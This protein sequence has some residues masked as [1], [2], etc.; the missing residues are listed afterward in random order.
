MSSFDQFES[1]EKVSEE[2]SKSN[3][4]IDANDEASHEVIE[5]VVIIKHSVVI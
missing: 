2:D 5:R 4:F 3:C 1:Y